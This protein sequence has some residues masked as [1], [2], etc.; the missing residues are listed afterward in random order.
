MIKLIYQHTKK[1][2]EQDPGTGFWGFGKRSVCNIKEKQSSKKEEKREPI[3]ER[4]IF[5]GALQPI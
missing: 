5:D 2:G 4:S 1:G 3:I